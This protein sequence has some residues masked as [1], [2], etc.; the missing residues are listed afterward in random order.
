MGWGR[1]AG[2]TITAKVRVAQNA[3]IFFSFF[4]WDTGPVRGIGCSAW[5][6]WLF[7]VVL[8]TLNASLLPIW[9]IAAEQA[10]VKVTAIEIRGN[11]RIMLP[12][13]SG[14]LTL[15]PGDPYTPENVRGQIKIL[16]E[17]GFFEEVQVETESG[18]GG[19]ALTILVREKPF[20]TEIVFDGNKALSDDK[21]KEK[22]TIK[23]QA[24]LDQLQAKESAEKIRLAYQGDGYFNCEVIPVVQTL[25]EDRKR[26]T[27][28]VKEGD[29]ARVKTVNFDGLHAATKDEMFKVMATREW[30]P[31]Y[32]L[33]TQLKLPSFVSDAGVLKREEMNNDV[34]RI[35]EVLLNKG[36]LN[37]KVGL[38]TV[39]LS[40]DKKWFVVT[41]AVMEGEPFTI[42][43]I[44]FRGNTVFEDPELRE[45]LKI[46]EGEIFQRQ[47]IRDEITRLK[48]LYG[49][50]GYAFAEVSPNVNP[51]MAD[52]TATI[53]LT[54]NEGELMRIRQI[55]ING[56]EK[57]KDNVIRREMRVDEQDVI[58][59]PALKRSFQ[60]LNNLNFF[61]TVEILPAK[62]GPDKVDLNVRVKEKPTG[63]FSVGGGFSTLDQ[64][65][66]IADITEGNIG[67]NGWMG[68][69]RGQLGQQRQIGL[70]TFRNPYLN[71]SLTSMQLDIY[72]SATNYFTY[73]ERKT[74]A[75]VTFGRWFSEYVTGTIG[76]VVEEI[77]YSSPTATAP[78][79]IT[80]Q[81][82]SQTTTGFRASLTR[83]TRDYFQDPRTGWR[84]SVA[85][86]LGTSYLGGSN[87][88]FKYTLDVNKYTPLPYDTR[89]SVRARYGVVQG[90]NS[91]GQ[92]KPVPLTELYFVGG[93]N[94]MRGFVFGKA[95]P[96]T[97]DNRL[98]GAASELIFNF[99][100]IFTISSEAKL[101]GVIFFDYGK[102]F[103]DDTVSF[104]LRSAAGLE[105]RWVSPFGPLRAAYGIN[106]D[107]NSG[108]RKGVFEFTIGTIF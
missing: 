36:Y 75:S 66:A 52:R 31:W 70:I 95:G 1:G 65:V 84:T 69:V 80:N 64:L 100:Y 86:S 83:D 73:F 60:R 76:P 35:K 32:G 101:N 82:G 62:V 46:K 98:L 40:D 4:L 27:F 99:D 51:N 97:S 94:T 21:L 20:I 33:V 37:V 85:V 42:G 19:V 106:L 23:S 54:V 108:E 9:A 57:T 58:D 59:T 102:G 53:I 13:I 7:I 29:K 93:I 74:G 81:I 43:E 87:D 17:T 63:Q 10:G 30:I 16:Y 39:E 92:T 49:N 72:K 89:L 2:G 11:K 79:I 88:F 38:P 56:N 25:D 5:S 55:N 8:I 22:I 68:R 61:E 12:A 50:R 26:L 71:D 15:K 103:S 48:D 96:V 3:G 105:G 14:R 45:G 107:P 28:L 78:A 104:P 91:D 44:G 6:C 34:D 18:A 90:L 77:T 67:G 24:F 47:K 41:Y